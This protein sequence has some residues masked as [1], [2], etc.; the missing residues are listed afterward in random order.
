MRAS[1]RKANNITGR[2]GAARRGGDSA[3][4]TGKRLAGKKVREAGKVSHQKLG[5]QVAQELLKLRPVLKEI[6][7]AL[8][9]RLEG[10]LAG[11][12]LSL[13]GG[14]VAGERPILPHAVVLS[15]MLADIK[16]LKVKSKKGRVKDLRRMEAL[17][18]SLS[19]RIPPVGGMEVEGRESNEG[20]PER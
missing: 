20:A 7:T 8:L 13:D 5:R 12:A 18:E 1:V 15:E 19:V 4:R 14:G 6:G 3:K 11:L 9:D 16:S 2:K 17:L 10:E